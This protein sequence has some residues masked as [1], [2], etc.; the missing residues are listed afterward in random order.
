MDKYINRIKNTLSYTMVT[1]KNPSEVK[2]LDS[3]S[4]RLEKR[5]PQY[6]LEFVSLGHNENLN[7]HMATV[8]YLNKEF[9][10]NFFKE[11][12]YKQ[13]QQHLQVYHKLSY[14]EKE[15]LEK[16]VVDGIT[17][18]MDFSQGNFHPVVG[19]HI[20]LKFMCCLIEDMSFCV[21]FNAERILSGVWCGIQA[22]SNTPPSL[23][24]LYTVQGVGSDIDDGKVWLHTHGLNRCGFIELEIMDSNIESANDHALILSNFADWII[25]NP[26]PIEEG[27]PII[28][29][30]DIHEDNIVLTWINWM[31]ANKQ[32]DKMLI[33]GRNYRDVEHSGPIGTVYAV[34]NRE[35]SKLIPLSEVDTSNYKSILMVLPEQESVRTSTMAKERVN[36]LRNW[37]ALSS[38]K[39]RVKI[40]FQIKD[41]VA[42]KCGSNFEHLWCDLHKLDKDSVYCEVNQKPRYVDTV[43][44]GEKIKISL[45]N[46]SDWY[47]EVDDMQITPDSVYQLVE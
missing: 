15:T 3:I 46:L 24:Y 5:C 13:N 17:V 33:G 42:E 38:A 8:R 25:S 43:K 7:C 12:L 27:T 32:Y 4:E 29:G 23:K 11:P 37:S 26:K 40:A 14:A 35:G 2:S 16:D 31:E 34:E 22:K 28:I 18:A 45:D 39:A 9:K 1:P 36:F 6:G 19:L 47:L 10:I 21:D 20:Q 44:E 30:K 41:D